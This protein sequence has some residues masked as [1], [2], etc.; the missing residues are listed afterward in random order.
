MRTPVATALSL[1]VL[2]LAIAFFFTA[3]VIASPAP[4]HQGQS[5]KI[6]SR[7]AAATVPTTGNG[8]STIQA[9]QQY[10]TVAN[11]SAIG[12]NSTIRSAFLEA[13][14]VGT[15]FNS[16]MLNVM[17]ANAKNLT[18]DVALNEACGNL[19]AVA[20]QQVG[21]NFTM[22]IVGQFTFTENPVSVLNGPIMIGITVACLI[23][24][25]GPASA[26]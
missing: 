15:M 26:V 21:V 25:L 9:C 20:L 14:P 22:G 5:I 17:Q 23:I 13:S 2:F 11:L 24:I 18:T 4:N 8:L 6:V 10:S 12:S 3:C 16:A 7:Q 1:R 19:T